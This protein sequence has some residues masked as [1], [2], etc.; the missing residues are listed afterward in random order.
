MGYLNE[1]D[2]ILALACLEKVL[3]QMG[4]KFELGAGLKAAQE[5]FLG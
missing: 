4:Y 5:V 2:I 1:F 3:F